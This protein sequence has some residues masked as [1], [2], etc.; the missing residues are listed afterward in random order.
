[1]R[2][3]AQLPKLV[4]FCRA[5]MIRALLL[6]LILA[7]VLNLGISPAAA[8][9][10]RADQGIDVQHSLNPNSRLLAVAH[11][12]RGTRAAKTSV[13]TFV[14]PIAQSAKL[15]AVLPNFKFEMVIFVSPNPHKLNLHKLPLRKFIITPF[16]PRR[17]SD[18]VGGCTACTGGGHFT[19]ITIHGTTLTET[20]RGRLF[21]SGRTRFT[22]ALT[23][24]GKIGRY[25]VLGVHVVK[26]GAG[27]IIHIPHLGHGCLAADAPLSNSDFLSR[28]ALPTVPCSARVPSGDHV[29]LNHPLELASNHVETVSGHAAGA[30]WLSVFLSHSKCASDA[31]AE[32]ARSTTRR[33]WFVGGNFS[34]PFA[35]TDTAPGFFC[36]Y[37]QTGG[38]F[39]G[40]PDG[41][42]SVSG[43]IPY[44]AGDSLQISGPSSVAPGGTAQ[45]TFTGSASIAE[46]FYD[47]ISYA[48]CAATA[49]AEFQQAVGLFEAPV[50]GPFTKSVNSVPFAQSG[51]VCA[52]LQVGAPSGTTPTGPTVVS[53]AEAVSVS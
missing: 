17:E 7:G 48:P 5:S 52:Y 47:F 27:V 40:V 4:L 9:S 30:R 51:F 8:A 16:Y 10:F 21:V 28:R 46:E 36:I 39:H 1:M 22:Q 37:L 41:R 2:F 50:Q 24:P 25:Q 53:A 6:G 29:T 15:N 3:V 43:G 20:V 11:P 42:V 49:Q 33:F 34:E 35:A 12:G 38:R 19:K 23:A 45:D 31:Q 18:P 14:A 32:A 44:L 26:A 13:H